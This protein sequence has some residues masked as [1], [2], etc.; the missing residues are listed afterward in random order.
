MLCFVPHVTD[1]L[2]EGMRF[3]P[4]HIGT[5]ENRLLPVRRSPSFCRADEG[6]AD[7]DPPRG[8]RDDQA[9]NL[10]L[11]AHREEQTLLGPR[12]I[13]SSEVG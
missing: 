6:P 9:D 3:Q 5:N 13:S 8:R 4:S 11:F 2:I 10:N 7:T 1:P 12:A